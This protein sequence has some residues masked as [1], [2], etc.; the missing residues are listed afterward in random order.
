ME[1]VTVKLHNQQGASAGDAKV[2]AHVFGQ[3]LKRDLVHQVMLAMR[4]NR[5]IS[6]ADVKD[7]SEV[8]GG[9]KKPW[10]QKGTGRARHGSRRSPIWI[11]GGV[12][13]GPTSE[14]DYSQKVNKKM[15]ARALFSALSEKVRNNQVIFLDSLTIKDGKTKNAQDVLTALAGIEGFETLNT[16]KNKRNV[17]IALEEKNP[18]LERSLNNLPHVQFDEL[19]NINV[20]DV[21]DHR[22]MIIVNP[23]AASAMLEKRGKVSRNPLPAEA[24]AA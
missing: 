2:S 13:H 5:R 23:E 14:K 4:A 18:E 8:R 9:G 10:R 24:P 21:L 17:F 7:R 6:T 12:T 16:L 15:R 19:R 3:E 1:T 20:L 22:Y 11:G